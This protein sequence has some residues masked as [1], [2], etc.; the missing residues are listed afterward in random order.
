MSSS[1]SPPLTKDTLFAGLLTPTPGP[2]CLPPP[3]PGMFSFSLPHGPYISSEPFLPLSLQTFSLWH[4]WSP[5]P[6][7]CP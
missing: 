1:A 5:T 2:L 6:M 3:L 7:I 4:F